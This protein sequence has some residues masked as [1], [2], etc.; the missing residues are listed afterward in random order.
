M[1]L[2]KVVAYFGLGTNLGTESEMLSILCR[3]VEALNRVSG[4]CVTGESAIAQTEPWG[5]VEQ[6]NFRNMAVRIETTLTP[7]ELLSAVKKIENDL[8]RVPSVKWGPRAIDIDIL[9]YGQETVNTDDLI[10]PHQYLV[11]RE[12]AWRP[13]LELDSQVMLPG[14]RLLCDVVMVDS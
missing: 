4:V 1:K 9:L 7:H 11:A 3:A 12:F 6:P 13:V 8:G 14:G 5:G 2:D 10:I